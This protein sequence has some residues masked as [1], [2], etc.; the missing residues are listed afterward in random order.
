LCDV[1][2]NR[3]LSIL[4]FNQN[5]VGA[6]LSPFDSYL[7]LRGIK[8]LAVRMKQ[9]QAN[10]LKMSYF[11]ENHRKVKKVI[12]PGLDSHPE[13]HLALKQMSGF[14]GMI[15]FELD[16]DSKGAKR[17]VENLTLPFIAESLG[18]VESLIEVPALMTHSSLSKEEREKIGLNESLIRFS[19]GIEN[20]DDLVADVELALS[21]L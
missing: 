13:H 9:H 8:T 7:I 18:G 2:F 17:F 5:A 1:E 6:I 12:Y 10:A 4:K 3:T 16:S 20:I 15:S 14:G 11:L 19:V 21:T